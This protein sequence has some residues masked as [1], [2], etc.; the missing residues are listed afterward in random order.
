MARSLTSPS[1]SRPDTPAPAR[2]AN[3][4]ATVLVV[5]GLV[6]DVF[7]S[8]WDELGISLPVDRVLLIA[9]LIWIVLGFDGGEGL[10][11]V[12]WRLVHWLLVA[13]TAYALLSAMLVGTFTGA[14]RLELLDAYGIVPYACFALSP[15]LFRTAR[16]RRILIAGLVVLGGYLGVVAFLEVVGPSALVYPRYI[17]DQSIRIHR[18][19]SRGPFTESVVNGIALY[20]GFL[21]AA[22]ATVTWRVR[23]RRRSA[24]AVAVLCILG[25]FLTLTRSIWLATVI[26]TVL[27]LALDR[28]WRTRYRR[29]VLAAVAAVGLLAIAVPGLTSK[30][31]DRAETEDTVWDRQNLNAA[32]ARMIEERPLFGFGWNR[33]VDESP[34]Y[35]EQTDTYPLTGVGRELHNVLLSRTVELGIVGTGLWASALGVAIAGAVRRRGPDEAR[36]F[37]VMALAIS[38]H[39]LIVSLFVPLSQPYPTL[40]LWIVLGAATV[41]ADTT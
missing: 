9:G 36:P 15:A 21:A 4:V 10:R 6:L 16:Q 38:A 24:G 12:R 13:A 20:G 1:P 37:Q 18:G 14:A 11:R 29:L 3:T 8:H 2:D 19:R 30:V 22:I 39:W 7:S 34:E 28:T 33:F 40:L 32:A 25:T 35:F 5:L 26:A 41:S 31:S 17:V 27:V 23:A